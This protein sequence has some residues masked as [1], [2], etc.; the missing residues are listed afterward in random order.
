M[1]RVLINL[2]ALHHNLQVIDGWMRR[3]GARWTL[4]TKVLCG[5]EPTLRAMHLLGVRSFGE[6]RMDNLAAI[7]EI[8]PSIESWYL[9]VPSPTAI[10]DVV[11]Y[12]DVSLNSESEI[13][14]GINEEAGKQGRTH[15]VIVMIELGDLRE[16]ILPG[17][18]VKFYDQVFQLPNIE[19]LGIGANLGCLAGVVPTVDQ[20]MQLLLYRELLELK[21]G[22]Q[23]PLV[24][25]GT[26]ATLPLVLDGQLP[27]TINHFR[28]G[29]S[30]FLGTDLING[31]TLPGLRSDTVILEAELIEIKRKSLTPL[32]ETA[33][34]A[35]FSSEGISEE[36][37]PGQRGY[38]ALVGVGQ[39]DTDVSGLKPENPNYQLAG[40][41][42]DITVINIGDSPG[43]LAVGD[44]MRFQPNYAAL[45][46]LMGNRYLEKQIVPDLET[47]GESLRPESLVRLG[48]VVG[49]GP[50]AQPGG[51]AAPV[52]AR[53]SRPRTAPRPE[54]TDK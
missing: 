26:S 40:A 23:L 33:Q 2:E 14:R 24:S 9:R 54:V 29:E 16:G 18:L 43:G 41:S 11:R 28:V 3:H 38:R 13:I 25:G 5:H 44:T 17:T 20:F 50:A 32:A 36:V 37:S 27:T 49:E 19:V 1:N 42:S 12:C 4:V 45:V 30:L 53:T 46:R 31:G 47:F 52:T 35:P 8:D 10:P 39:L 21:F 6:S 22:H 51:P 15:H 7:R 34:V 48:P